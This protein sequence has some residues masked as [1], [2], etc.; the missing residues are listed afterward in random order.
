MS[1]LLPLLLVSKKVYRKT[2]RW[3]TK[4]TAREENGNDI[5]KTFS[6]YIFLP[7]PFSSCTYGLEFFWGL[8]FQ[9][10]LE[11]KAN[12]GDVEEK[13]EFLLKIGRYENLTE[14]K[15]HIDIFHT[16]KR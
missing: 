4:K 6:L 15:H 3:T 8:A 5:K 11:L 2:S 7:Y 1:C 10:P 12:G 9:F 14:V 16:F 13:V